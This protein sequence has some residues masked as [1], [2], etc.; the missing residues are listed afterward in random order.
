M[1]RLSLSFKGLRAD[2]YQSS[3]YVQNIY[4]FVV[5][6]HFCAA[7]CKSNTW[8]SSGWTGILHCLVQAQ[9]LLKPFCCT[10]SLPQ[11]LWYLWEGRLK[12]FC[13]K[14]SQWNGRIS[15]L[16]VKITGLYSFDPESDT[17]I[18]LGWFQRLCWNPSDLHPYEISIRPQCFHFSFVILGP[19]VLLPL[20]NT[21]FLKHQ[22][23]LWDEGMWQK[24]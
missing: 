1:Q 20:L 19:S 18:S 22:M 12:T 4:L 3:N 6:L 11:H 16:T 24:K 21:M 7:N 5:K 9:E 14:F 13:S 10:L 17:S 23:C 8:A 15:G 2:T